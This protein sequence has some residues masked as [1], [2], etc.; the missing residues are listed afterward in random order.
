[1]TY[2]VRYVLTDGA[3]VTLPELA[4]VLHRVNPGYE[5]DENLI[6]LNDEE[7]GQIEINAP[8]DGLFEGDIMLLNEFVEQKRD[9]EVLRL[10][11]E[12]ATSLVT[13]Q[14]LHGATDVKTQ[15]QI[16]P[17][18]YWLLANRPGLLAVE[19]GLFYDSTGPIT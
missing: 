2:Y 3:T 4:S 18:F 9:P 10:A 1:M 6:L 14:V 7:L 8:G 15:E 16:E 11:L 17:L 12:R 5:V 19:G 13:V